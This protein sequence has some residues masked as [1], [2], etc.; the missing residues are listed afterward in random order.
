MARPERR[1]ALAG[2]LRETSPA[3]EFDFMNTPSVWVTKASLGILS[4]ILTLSARAAVDAYLKL[5]AIPG[6]ATELNHSNWIHV[7]YFQQRT[8][9]PPGGNAQFSELILVKS[10]DHASPGLMAACA[11]Q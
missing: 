11:R 7:L 3:T 1:P 8:V 10:L 2:T 9:S 6:E 5:P 4:I